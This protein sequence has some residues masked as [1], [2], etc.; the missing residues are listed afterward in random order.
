MSTADSALYGA[1]ACERNQ[2]TILVP[3]SA[4]SQAHVFFDNSAANR[5]YKPYPV[6]IYLP[7]YL[8]ISLLSYPA[9]PH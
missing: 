6:T 9:A 5:T 1:C 2:Y 8:P 4:S 3:A 7:I